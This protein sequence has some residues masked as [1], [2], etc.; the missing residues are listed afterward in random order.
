MGTLLKVTDEQRK[1]VRAMSGYGIP[2]DDIATLLEID[3]KTLRKHFRRELDR[4]SIEATAKVAQSLFN[5]ATVEKNVA[6]AIFW[7]K[8]RA[9]GGRSTRCRSAHGRCRTCRMLSWTVFCM[10]S[11]PNISSSALASMGARQRPLRTRD[12][13]LNETSLSTATL[14]HHRPTTVDRW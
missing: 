4:G 11:W 3:P 2:H 1:T 5:M 7:M 8:A 6:A 10:T 13:P 14:V 9:G 12:P